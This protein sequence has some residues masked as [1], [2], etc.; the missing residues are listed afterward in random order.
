MKKLG[1]PLG[2]LVI[3][4]LLVGCNTGAKELLEATEKVEEQENVIV[5]QINEVASEESKL[6]EQFSETLTDDK[7]LKT[8]GDSSSLVF[9]NINNRT[10]SLESIQSATNELST[11]ADEVKEIDG[12][13]LPEEDVKDFQTKLDAVTTSLND[14]VD[15][16]EGH[17]KEEEMYFNSLSTDEATYEAFSDGLEQINE[18]HKQSNDNLIKIDKELSELSSSRVSIT[19]QLEEDDKK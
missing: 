19:K 13:D 17:L 1:L 4:V 10:S 7:E 15:I 5:E 2:L 12:K 6:H 14:W 18:L 11:Q 16:Y 8:M 3:S 9:E